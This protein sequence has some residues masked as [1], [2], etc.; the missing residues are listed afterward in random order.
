MKSLFA[1]AI[2]WLTSF[3]VCA[4]TLHLKVEKLPLFLEK[5]SPEWQPESEYDDIAPESY[6]DRY[7]L[8]YKHD[9][10]L[11]RNVL[12]VRTYLYRK[13]EE[14]IY[15]DGRREARYS[16]ETEPDQIRVYFSQK[17]Y[18]RSVI[19]YKGSETPYLSLSNTAYKVGDDTTLESIKRI[20][21]GVHLYEYHWF[22][23]FPQKLSQSQVE[24]ATIQDNQEEGLI[25]I[26]FPDSEMKTKHTLERSEFNLQ[27]LF[28]Y[29]RKQF[30]LDT[31]ELIDCLANGFNDFRRLD[32]T[33]RKERISKSKMTPLQKKVFKRSQEYKSLLG[34]MKQQRKELKDLLFCLPLKTSEYLLKHKGLEV[35]NTLLPEVYS[36]PLSIR[37]SNLGKRRSKYSGRRYSS[38][39]ERTFLKVSEEIGVGLEKQEVI[40][41]FKPSSKLRFRKAVAR[42]VATSPCC[43]GMRG[44][45]EVSFPRGNSLSLILRRASLF[46]RPKR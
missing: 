20:P 41:C 13:H 33:S 1:I 23:I 19:S 36:K 3:S 18:P 25:V 28:P 9:L 8:K 38:S 46:C 11:E 4:E 39:P 31:K 5:E 26:S 40:G 7:S 34:E 30:S 32:L 27:R 45:G 10:S 15:E 24:K 37:F 21:N 43:G 35:S 22:I 2:L 17:L 12:R 14:T 29:C 42:Y 6:T 44:D 16:S